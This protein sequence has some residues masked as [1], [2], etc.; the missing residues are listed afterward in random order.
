MTSK[1]NKTIKYS[2]WTLVR[3]L[4]NYIRPYR[5]KFWVATLLRLLGDV[6]NLYPAIAIAT[7]VTLFSKY[8]IGD[9]LDYFWYVVGLWAGASFL[10]SVL[11]PWAKNLMFQISEKAA[12][13][14]NLGATKHLFNLDMDWHEKENAGSK[15][16][17]IQRGSNGVDRIIRMWVNNYI[18]IT[19][20][21]IGI[22]IILSRGDKSVG[23][24]MIS[25]VV[26]HFVFS[27]S[28]LKKAKKIVHEINEQE[29]DISGLIFQ[30]MNN[31]R[32]IKVVGIGE[33]I[34]NLIFAKNI[35]FFKTIKRR[36]LL[37]QVRGFILNFIGMFFRI[38]AF[39]FIGYGIIQ[40]RLEVGYLVL[41]NVYFMRVWQSVSELADT[42]Q[43]LII[44]KMAIA[45]MQE[46]LSEPVRI[47]DEMDKV[48]FPAKWNKIIAKNLSFAYGK[49]Q[50]LKNVSFEINKGER[51]GIIGLSGAGKTTL[52]KLLLK[53]NENYGGEILF[54]NTPLKNIKKN[55]Y[56]KK[57]GVVLQ[58]TEVF[59]FTLRE[60]I[61]I[62]A[63]DEFGEDELQQALDIAHVTDFIGKLPKGIDTTIGEKGIKLSGG[64]KQRLG[65]A[66]A[67]YKKPQ[68]L[69]MDEATSHLDLESEEKIK[70]SLHKFF[71]K[72]TAVVIAHRLT[73]IKEMDKILV[74]ERGELVESGN[75]DELY[76]KKGRFFELWEK[77]KL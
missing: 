26:V 52:F 59:N 55:S 9:S 51:V 11:T 25:F 36:I 50:V 64:E 73:T 18:E 34:Y 6:V 37:F 29:E 13:D 2:T 1:E 10:R 5:K 54:D 76:S 30:A 15:L 41:F 70:D 65:I 47:D 71:Q 43:D 4:Y 68:V 56:L 60:N 17:K 40:G 3:D 32:S 66:R 62:A 75:F 20:N 74:I 48:D 45:R 23:L 33:K 53:E 46:L 14:I 77:Q 8:H 28:L 31:I 44:N 67:I 22:I 63:D 39:I 24:I 69:F 38:G 19:V 35:D 16:K 27:S 7:I 58:D 49:N 42:T 72:V 12:I 21:F 61:T 57:M